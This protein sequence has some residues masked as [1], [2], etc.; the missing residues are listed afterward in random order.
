[1]NNR[2]LV[3]SLV[4]FIS[5]CGWDTYDRRQQYLEAQSIPRVEV[6]ERLDRPEFNDALVIPRVQ[7]VRD[8]A[9]QQLEIGLPAPLNTASDVDQIII[10]RLGDD[11]WVFVDAAPSMVWPRLRQFWEDNNMPLSLADPARG[12]ME[13]EWISA[14]DGDADQVLETLKSGPGW[15]GPGATMRHKF[16]LTIE[17]GVREGSTEVYLKHQSE[18]LGN[19][20]SGEPLDWAEASDDVVL[21]GALLNDLAYYL[22][23]HINTS[24]QVSKLAANIGGERVELMLDRQKPVLKYQLT[25]ER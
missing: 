3:L 19:T 17:T 12:V 7:D 14:T 1:M 15:V 13:S 4:F 5:A 8:I 23:D 18:P 2:I 6:P 25:F 10:K 20:I 24:V 22:G 21:E 11:R 9:G 16:Q